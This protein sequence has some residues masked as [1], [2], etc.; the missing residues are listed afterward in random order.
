M[1]AAGDMLMAALWELLEDKESFLTDM[2]ALGLPGVEISAH[3]AEKCGI[4][5]TQLRVA[6]RGA[7]EHEHHHHAHMHHHQ[8]NSLRDI[9]ALISALPIPE[10]VRDDALA[11]YRLLGDAEAQAHGKPVEQIHFHEVGTL[12]AVADIVGVCWLMDRLHPAQILASPVAVGSGQVHCAHGILPVP[13]PA[14]A[15]LLA[16]IPIH[17]GDTEGELCT[18][19]GAALLRHFVADFCAL[20]PLRIEKIGYGMGHKDFARANCVRAFWAERAEADT[21]QRSDNLVAELSCNLDDM[22]GEDIG[23]ALQVLLDAGALDVWTTPI[24]MKKCR[25]GVLLSC[26]CAVADADKFSALLLRHTSTLGVRKAL[27]ERITLPRRVETVH[28]PLGDVRVKISEGLGITKCKP[29]FDDL[30]RIADLDL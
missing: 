4:V 9:T 21:R 7:E 3:P 5:G 29:E 28:T 16:G 15:R 18:P 20:P 23:Y 17:A 30:A 1:G 2:N 8:H 10:K 27:L 19:T 26:L 22:T 11:V 24:G 13:A 14:T 25:P 6:I 12:D